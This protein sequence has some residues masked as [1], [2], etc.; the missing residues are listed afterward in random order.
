MKLCVETLRWCARIC[1]AES[2]ADE[3]LADL[4]QEAGNVQDA[5]AFYAYAHAE[6][7]AAEKFTEEADRIAE[8]GQ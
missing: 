8:A 4:Y 1:S 6:R 5:D 7:L 2:V 3:K